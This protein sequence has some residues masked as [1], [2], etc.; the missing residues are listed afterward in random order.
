[1]IWPEE[2]LVDHAKVNISDTLRSTCNKY[3]IS[4][5]IA[6]KANPIDKANIERAFDTVRE[7]FSEHVAGYKGP[8]V[9]ARGRGVEATARWRLEDLEEFFAEYVVC[10]YH[11][12]G[13]RERRPVASGPPGAAVTSEYLREAQPRDKEEW[14]SWCNRR[15]CEPFRPVTRA[16]FESWPSAKQKPWLQHRKLCTPTPGSSTPGS[17]FEQLY[18][19]VLDRFEVNE[20]CEDGNY[21]S[22]TIDAPAQCVKTAVLKHIG[23]IYEAECRAKHPGR[24]RVLGDWVPVVYISASTGSTGFQLSQ[25]L[26]NFLNVPVRSST[27]NRWTVTDPVLKGLKYA[28]TELI[29]LD[30]LHMVVQQRGMGEETN[31]HLKGLAS[32]CAGTIIGAG[33][34]LDETNLFNDG[35]PAPPTRKQSNAPGRGRGRSAQ[36]GSRFPDLQQLAPFEIGTEDEQRYWAW[37]IWQ[38]EQRLRLFDHDVGS[39]AGQHWRDLHERAS[40]YIGPLTT[41]FKLAAVRAIRKGEEKITPSL[42]DQIWM[43]F[44]S[45]ADLAAVRERRRRAAARAKRAAAAEAS[46]KAG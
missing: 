20:D 38:F 2:I 40:G 11:P 46:K 18:D 45:E 19:Q 30:D 41:L 24:D 36:F 44:A 23:E 31:N 22:V 26:G 25:A 34:L 28:G 12:G 42:L 8:E 43:D 4:L 7:Q 21:L 17:S 29:L 9:T 3:G 37:P 39:L 15:R 5:G 27:S 32:H 1:M 6:R 14:R 16:K 35:R 10:T 13:D 33:I